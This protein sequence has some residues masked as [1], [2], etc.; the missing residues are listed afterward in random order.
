MAGILALLQSALALLLLV[1]NTPTLPV[2]LRDQIITLA[3]QAVSVAQVNLGG[4]PIGTVTPYTL[5]RP[6]EE[7]V[8]WPR[9]LDEI[10]PEYKSIS[11]EGL[12]LPKVTLEAQANRVHTYAQYRETLYE[13][14]N[15]EIPVGINWCIPDKLEI[16]VNVG[17]P[18]KSYKPSW[19]CE[20]TGNWS[21]LIEPYGQWIEVENP[22]LGKYG[23]RCG[24]DK[25]YASEDY[26]VVTQGKITCDR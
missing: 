10:A 19:T 11:E 3:N 12:L 9:G 14:E 6:I 23:I 7:P 22:T 16:L 5:V 18:D 8:T 4:N 17:N 20:K 13:N 25:S 15:K 21:G 24:G 26:I 2:E 1:Q